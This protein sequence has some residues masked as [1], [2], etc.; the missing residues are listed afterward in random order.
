[1]T[2]QHICDSFIADFSPFSPDPRATAA[3]LSAFTAVEKH[4]REHCAA[5]DAYAKRRFGDFQ[6]VE[7]W[8]ALGKSPHLS[9]NVFKQAELLSIPKSDVALNLTSSGTQGQKSQI[10]LDA[11]SLKRALTMVDRVFDAM[12][13]KNPEIEVNYLIFAHEPREDHRRGTTFTGGNLTNLTKKRE[14]VFALRY[15][16]AKDDWHFDIDGVIAALTRFSSSEIPTRILGFPSFLYF[17]LKEHEQRGSKP[18]ALPANS[19]VISGGGWK[20][21][22]DKE[23]PKSELVNYFSHWLG[24]PNSFVRD[25]FGMVEHGL[26]YIECSQHH[27]H[28]PVYAEALIRD[29]GSLTLLP[30]GQVGLLQFCSAFN[31]AMPNHAI[32]AMDYGTKNSGCSCGNTRPYIE[33]I[34]RAGVAKHKGCAVSALDLANSGRALS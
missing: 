2:I 4:Q 26:P 19:Y 20:V 16:A 30:D 6:P 25:S 27:M 9:V 18:F 15:D 22:R 23:V 5:Y 1:M 10:F 31:T 21:H 17:A 34:G 33:I 12:G 14:V 29:P 3:F 8:E 24:M 28:V 13:L 11:P 7:T 32:L